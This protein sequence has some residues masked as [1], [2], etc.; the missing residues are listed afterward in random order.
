M[1]AITSISNSRFI[2]SIVTSI[3]NNPRKP[4]LKPNPKATDVSG[5]KVRAASFNFNLSN[6]S[7]NS[8]NWLF[9]IG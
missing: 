3:C 4:V 2:R 1:V 8:S 9:S 6:A 5:S 7:L